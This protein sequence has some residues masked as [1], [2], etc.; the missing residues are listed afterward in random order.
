MSVI[1][2]GGRQGQWQTAE[3]KQR[4]NDLAETA[5]GRGPQVV[6]RHEEPI[7]VVLSPGITVG[8]SGRPMPI[9]GTCSPFTGE[10]VEPATLSLAGDA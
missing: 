1:P 2:G 3:A 9:S 4:F 7:V 6:M 5:A 8:L 10:D